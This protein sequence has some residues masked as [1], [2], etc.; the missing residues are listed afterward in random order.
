MTDGQYETPD[1]DRTKPR[2]APRVVLASAGVVVATLFATVAALTSGSGDAA[3]AARNPLEDVVSKNTLRSAPSQTSTTT[4]GPDALS[5][6]EAPS[7]TATVPQK[8]KISQSAGVT[9]TVGA[10]SPQ[11]TTVPPVTTVSSSTAES[12]STVPETSSEPVPSSSASVSASAASASSSAAND[13]V[14]DR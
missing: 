5:S 1:P 13:G 14:G 7:T 11:E 10:T 9:T 3:P 6:V 8:V 2:V 12:S 4:P